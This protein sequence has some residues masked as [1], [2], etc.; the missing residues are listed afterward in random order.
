MQVIMPLAWWHYV[1]PGCQKLYLCSKN[2]R[3]S[4]E[5]ATTRRSAPK[6]KLLL[7]VYVVY[8]TCLLKNGPL[9]PG[10]VTLGLYLECENATVWWLACWTLNL[11]A[12]ASSSGLRHSVVSLDKKL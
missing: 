2:R 4:R 1:Y 11:K 6:E 10:F 7:T 3:A 9:E 8:S 12:S 5:A